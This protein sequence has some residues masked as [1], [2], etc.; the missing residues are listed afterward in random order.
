MDTMVCDQLLNCK[1]SEKYVLSS[2]FAIWT[3]GSCWFPKTQLAAKLMV[4]ARGLYRGT[5]PVAFAE[6]QR[7]N[8]PRAAWA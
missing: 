8:I 6:F 3:Y 4:R 7:H 1:M 5:K 2:Y